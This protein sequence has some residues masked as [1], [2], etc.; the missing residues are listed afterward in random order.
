MDQKMM[1]A[2]MQGKFKMSVLNHVGHVVQ[3]DDPRHV[4]ELF[5]SFVNVFKIGQE[6]PFVNK[7]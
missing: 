2:H 5:D 6:L 1:I 4:A 3:E 7:R